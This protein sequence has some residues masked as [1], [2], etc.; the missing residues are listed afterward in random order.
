MARP[1]QPE[2]AERDERRRRRLRRGAYLL[3]SLFTIGNMLLGF[4]AIVLAFRGSQIL[5]LEGG[6]RYF[7][8]AALL[9]FIAAILDTLDGRIAR[10][11]GTDS[12]FGREY[13]SLADLFTF[14]AAPALLT[15]FW[16][17]QGLGRVGWLVPLYYM[18]CTATRLARFNVQTRIVD[19]RYF[20][21]LPSPAA[22][23]AVCSLLFYVPAADGW[24]EAWTLFV[25]ITLAVAGTLEVSTFR[26]WSP[27]QIDLR[28][29]WS[30]RAALPLALIVLVVVL[31]PKAVFLVIGA[32]Y[33][34]SG[35]V[36]WAVGRLRRKGA[37]PGG[38]PPPGGLSGGP[39]EG[40]PEV[41]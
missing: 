18:V 2:R 3:P 40:P 12:E 32:V 8:R 11:T 19:T 6:D 13:D 21:G 9:I 22:A 16:D 26:Y 28:K 7:A 20:V 33:A 38:E 5:Y 34:L 10:L 30:Y 25:L 4:Y 29:R 23:G 14:G 17:L 15:F 41:P 1:E 35:P 24:R 31:E 27:K 39:G 37:A 36:I